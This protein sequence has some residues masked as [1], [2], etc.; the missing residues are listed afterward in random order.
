MEAIRRFAFVEP[1]AFWGLTIYVSS[2]AYRGFIREPVQQPKFDN[3]REAVQYVQKNV[4][5]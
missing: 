1:V 3:L 4:K 2:L 5:N